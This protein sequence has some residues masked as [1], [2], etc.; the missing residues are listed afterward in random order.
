MGRKQN[1]KAD[2]AQSATANR[3]AW[4]NQRFIEALTADF[5]THGIGVIETLREKSPRDYAKICADLLPKVQTSDAAD[6]FNFRSV[7]SLDQLVEKLARD[8]SDWGLADR[9][10]SL[11]NKDNKDQHLS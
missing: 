6:Q 1:G 9:F 5:E 7:D 4:L 3:R 8:I 10:I 11:L 2:E